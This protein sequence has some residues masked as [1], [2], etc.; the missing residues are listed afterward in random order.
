MK[1]NW[2]ITRSNTSIENLHIQVRKSIDLNRGFNRTWI[3]LDWVVGYGNNN[4]TIT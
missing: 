4:I 1:G 2:E 3:N